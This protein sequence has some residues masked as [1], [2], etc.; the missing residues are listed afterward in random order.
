MYF[1]AGGSLEQAMHRRRD[2]PLR[3]CL[4]IAR[5]CVRGLN[6][7]HLANPHAMIHRDLKPSNIMFAGLGTS[8]GQVR[9]CMH[10]MYIPEVLLIP[11][12]Y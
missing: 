4:E 12:S 7:L 10:H 1:T 3:R 5:E 2:L 9:T 8:M 11:H 6:Y